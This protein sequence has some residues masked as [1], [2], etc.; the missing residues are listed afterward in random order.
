[1]AGLSIN[2]ISRIEIGKQDPSVETLQMIADGLGV[3][4]GVLLSKPNWLEG[5]ANA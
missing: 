4:L 1:M 2:T 3:Q 5:V